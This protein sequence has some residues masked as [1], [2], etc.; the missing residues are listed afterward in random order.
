MCMGPR[1]RF[2]HYTVI[3]AAA[4]GYLCYPCADD[5]SKVGCVVFKRTERGKR[6][7]HQE[8]DNVISNKQLFT[9]L[10]SFHMIFTPFKAIH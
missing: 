4:D 3:K 1:R 9:E 8:Q 7:K 6:H 10:C 2:I 5:N